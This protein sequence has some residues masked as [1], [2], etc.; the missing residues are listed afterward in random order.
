MKFTLF[1]LCTFLALPSI[2][3]SKKELQAENQ[4]LKAEAERLKADL[5]TLKK[6][7]EIAV[8]TNPSRVSYSI[9][10]MI[11]SNIQMQGVDSL[12]LKSVVAGLSDVIEKKNLKIDQNEC[13]VIVQQ[14]MENAMESRTK[15]SKEEGAAFLAQN[16]TAPGVQT[17]ASG[18]QYKM[19]NEGTGKKPGPTSTVTVHY[20][21]KL[22][23]GTEFD[24]SVGRGQPATFPLNQVIPGWT[25]GL[26]LIKE[27]GKAIL[28]IPYE[29]GYGERGAGGQ[30][31]PYATLVFEVELLKVQ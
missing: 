12:E 1:V 31:P 14:Y 4:K 21:G 17:T 27:G 25:E 22:T 6:A 23:D 11:G 18:L 20:V 3:Q 28:Y 16:K 26:Q 5:E 30:I 19:I 7:Q 9:G 10:V 8:T 29:L 13:Q 15:K 2:A 24:S